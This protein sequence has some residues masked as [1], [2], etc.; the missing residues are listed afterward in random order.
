MKPI[1]VIT[2]ATAL[3]VGAPLFAKGSKSPESR[4]NRMDADRDGRITQS[5]Y[6]GKKAK[7]ADR[8]MKKFQK[9]DTNHDGAVSRDEF[10][11]QK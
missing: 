8:R 2:I 6:Q 10:L 3:L 7:N 4:F 11:A 9:L 1:A 5:E